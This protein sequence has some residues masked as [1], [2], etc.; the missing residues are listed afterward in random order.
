MK[1]IKKA[2]LSIFF[3]AKLASEGIFGLSF[4]IR[5]DNSF[6]ES[7]IALNSSF[8]TSGFSSGISFTDAVK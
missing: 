3:I 4:I 5:S 1:L 2:L 7:I 8:S 6:I